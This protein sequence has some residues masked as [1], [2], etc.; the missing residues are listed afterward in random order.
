MDDSKI[1]ELKLFVESCKSDPSILHNPSLGFFKTYLQSLGAKIPPSSTSG[2]DN[3][4]TFDEDLVES[5]LELDD[6]DVVNPDDD[7]PQKMGDLSVEVNEESRDLAQILK[8]KAMDSISEGMFY[9]FA[10]AF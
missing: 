2:A 10:D 1:D 7:P 5:D 9:L 8:S 6:S 3:G 4:H